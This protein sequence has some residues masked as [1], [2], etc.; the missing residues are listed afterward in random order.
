[1]IVKPYPSSFEFRVSCC[2]D[3]LEKGIKEA[4]APINV[5]G[6]VLKSNTTG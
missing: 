2:R 1:M 5:N 3:T 6:V 4:N